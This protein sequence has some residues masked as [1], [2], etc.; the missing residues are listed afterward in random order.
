MS[1]P[2]S[3]RLQWRNKTNRNER[4]T[5]RVTT[6]RAAKDA[7][8]QVKQGS[9]VKNDTHTRKIIKDTAE[10][11][12]TPENQLSGLSLGA[13]I[14]LSLSF[15]SAEWSAVKKDPELHQETLDYFKSKKFDIGK[16]WTYWRNLQAVQPALAKVFLLE[17]TC[18]FWQDDVASLIDGVK[19][20]ASNLPPSELAESA[21]NER[22]SRRLKTSSSNL[23]ANQDPQSTSDRE[24]N[25]FPGVISVADPK[26]TPTAMN[27]KGYQPRRNYFRRLST[28]A[29]IRPL[30]PLCTGPMSAPTPDRT[31]STEESQLI[32]GHTS[33]QKPSSADT[34]RENAA[35]MESEVLQYL[36]AR[37]PK[38]EIDI[39]QYVRNLTPE[40]LRDFHTTI[41]TV[42]GLHHSQLKDAFVDLWYCLES[43]LAYTM[44]VELGLPRSTCM[45]MEV[46]DLQGDFEV[47]VK[48]GRQAGLHFLKKY[49]PPVHIK[50]DL[51]PKDL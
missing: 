20:I 38:R 33:S 47:R 16:W 36:L 44:E 21:A 51:F 12:Y 25:G 2:Q 41:F 37:G 31:R 19:H 5:A 45:S 15:T 4:T 10:S 32:V 27:E 18:L 11:R 35:K 49:Q 24:T 1:L 30:A 29:T 13:V 42:I 23:G 7:V 6:A 48:V 50:V 40:R 17:V 46:L 28:I 22:A 3:Q 8:A 39:R 43:A 34:G 14:T 26:S 9:R